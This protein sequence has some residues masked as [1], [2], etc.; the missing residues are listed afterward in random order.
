MSEDLSKRARLV[1]TYD[2]FFLKTWD[3]CDDPLDKSMIKNF[4]F[5]TNNP[6]QSGLSQWHGYA[7]VCHEPMQ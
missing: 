7:A 1:N 4:P 3:M 2:H 5:K 6:Q